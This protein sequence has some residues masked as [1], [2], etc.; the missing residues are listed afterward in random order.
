ML[1]HCLLVPVGRLLC[2]WLVLNVDR[3]DA[4]FG[5]LLLLLLGEVLSGLA[6]FGGLVGRRG[7]GG[8]CTRRQG[9]GDGHPT[10]HHALQRPRNAAWSH[11][12]YT[13]WVSSP[14][15]GN[16]FV[17]GGGRKS[18]VQLAVGSAVELRVNTWLIHNCPRCR[19]DKE[20]FVDAVS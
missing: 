8:V 6:M 4:M 13:R 16:N 9:V 14:D 2:D 17:L 7:L 15:L 5:S 12:N 18:L 3:S 10:W 11:S 20:L 19:G 1:F